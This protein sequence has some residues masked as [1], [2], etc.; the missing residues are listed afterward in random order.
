MG[1]APYTFNLEKINH[2][3]ALEIARHNL[4][5]KMNKDNNLVEEQH[6]AGCV[7]TLFLGFD[8]EDVYDEGYTPVLSRKSKRK[9]KSSCKIQKSLE[10]NRQKNNGLGA[11]AGYG[12]AQVKVNNDHP[13]CGIV[14]G[15]RIRK[16]I[17][18]I[19]DRSKL[20][21]QRCGEERYEYLLGRFNQ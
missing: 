11:Q 8:E 15:S 9:M 17:P 6:A 2:L 20:E 4:N 16:K 19:Y 18:S 12:A 10:R 14:S 13:V 21:L 3:K 7:Q 1:V 5:D